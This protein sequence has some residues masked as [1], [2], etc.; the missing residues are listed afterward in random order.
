MGD[1]ADFMGKAGIGLL[2]L[3]IG[4]GAAWL[5]FKDE[6]GAVVFVA[7]SPF[8]ACSKASES[9]RATR[10]TT[11]TG[12][13][14]RSRR[15][16]T[17]QTAARSR[18]RLVSALAT[19]ELRSQV[20]AHFV[21]QPATLGIVK[22]YRASQGDR[23]TRKA[24]RSRGCANGWRDRWR[25]RLGRAWHARCSVSKL[26]RSYARVRS[27]R[28]WQLPSEGYRAQ[29][30]RARGTRWPVSRWLNH[31]AFRSLQSRDPKAR[32]VAVRQTET[33]PASR[34]ASVSPRNCNHVT[35]TKRRTAKHGNE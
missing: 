27:G 32:P 34:S 11:T 13:G 22:S 15:R 16:S 17:V 18:A 28:A 26:R 2:G 1:A 6:Q 23:Y 30:R 8:F 21:W 9:W 20:A 33:T 19:S 25:H 3:A 7:H 5:F 12:P 31:A 24:K 14:S 4:I 35:N 29:A 10:A